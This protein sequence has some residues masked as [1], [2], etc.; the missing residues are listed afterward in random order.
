MATQYYSIE[1]RDDDTW[2]DY[3]FCKVAIDDDVDAFVKKLTER[4][5]AFRDAIEVYEKK[6]WAQYDVLGLRKTPEEMTCREF[7]DRGKFPANGGNVEKNYPEMWKQRREADAWNAQIRDEHKEKSKE[8][9]KQLEQ[10][11]EPELQKI[12]AEFPWLYKKLGI[13]K[14]YDIPM[15]FRIVK[16]NF[17]TTSINEI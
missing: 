9:M 4:C 13:S 12:S 16:R 14:S 6:S 17:K 2:S 1:T 7:K 8:L 5:L 3:C 11:L 15:E 10:Y